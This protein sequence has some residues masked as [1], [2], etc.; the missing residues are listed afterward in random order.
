MYL[1]ADLPLDELVDRL[2]TLA[3]TGN[4]AL[5]LFVAEQN[6]PDLPALAARLSA[7]G[8]RV[9]GAMFPAVI[10]ER[11]VRTSGLVALVQPLAA[12]PLFLN[13]EHF[14]AQDEL[15]L[16]ALR[17]RLQGFGQQR[18]VL[19]LIDNVGPHLLAA[20]CQHL[21]R[22]LGRNLNYIGGGAGSATLEPVPCVFDNSGYHP[23]KGAVIVLDRESLVDYSYGWR[24]VGLPLLATETHDNIIYKLNGKPAADV[25]RTQYQVITGM[26][27][28]QED[29]SVFSR[30]HLGMFA[31]QREKIM[32]AILG[33]TPEGGLVTGGSVPHN[34]TIFIMETTP[35]QMFRESRRVSAEMSDKLRANTDLL[36]VECITRHLILQQK[37]NEEL[38]GISEA[39]GNKVREMVGFLA[40]GE[41]TRLHNLG[42]EFLNESVVIGAAL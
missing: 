29:I 8:V 38:H 15:Q 40:L 13:I 4:D 20:F 9:I 6:K 10:A 39:I 5:V 27:I 24:A 32:R 25:F 18:M 36:V 30:L 37:L 14:G 33:V 19:V 42:I 12:E 21:Y 1:S 35:E 41:I 23:G 2:T 22:L 28:Q 17:S 31:Y 11:E 7:K 34:A 3:I 26:S 16:M